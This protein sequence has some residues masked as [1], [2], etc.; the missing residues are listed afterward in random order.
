MQQRGWLQLQYQRR[1]RTV[2]GGSRLKG[3]GPVLRSIK[4]AVASWGSSLLAVREGAV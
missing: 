3:A 4:R 2:A 1:L